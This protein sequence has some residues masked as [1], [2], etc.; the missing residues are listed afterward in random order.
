MKKIASKTAINAWLA[1]LSLK[2]S[3][4]KKC[5]TAFFKNITIALTSITDLYAA[6]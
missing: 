3:L 4:I 1:S 6:L 2:L 5:I